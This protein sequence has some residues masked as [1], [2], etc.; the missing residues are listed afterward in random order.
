MGDRWC[1]VDA[2]IGVGAFDD[3]GDGR[4]NPIYDQ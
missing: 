1:E 3:G 2:E 4:L